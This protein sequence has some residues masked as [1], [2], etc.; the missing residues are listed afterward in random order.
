MLLNGDVKDLT[1]R[2]L[3]VDEIAEQFQQGF[4][5]SQIVLVQFA[6]QL[7]LTAEQ[8]NQVSAAFGG[9]MMRGETCGAVIGALMAIGLKYGQTKAGDMQQKDIMSQKRAEFQSTF[10]EKYSSCMC[11]DLLEHDISSEQGLQQILE[12][13]LFF[14]FCPKVVEDVSKILDKILKG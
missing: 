1:E 8:A 11:K 9:G 6:E 4:D 7:G 12:K 5:C 3:S 10:L 13:N 14:T 2:R